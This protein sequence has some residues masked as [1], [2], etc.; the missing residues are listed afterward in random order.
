MPRIEGFIRLF[1]LIA[2]LG[3]GVAFSLLI[4]AVL[5]QVVGRFLGSSPVWAGK[6]ARYALLFTKAFGTGLAF[7]AGD[8]VNVDVVCDSLL[9][10]APWMLRLVAAIVTAGLALYFLPHAWRQVAIGKMQSS[11]ALGLRMD[12]AHVTG[13]LM[14]AFLSLFGAL[15]IP[16]TLTGTETGKPEKPEEET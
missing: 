2:R 9:G 11:P 10:R 14:L 15:S 4:G 13:W 6:L 12:F 7:R 16:D 1:M 3:T 8:L 5:I